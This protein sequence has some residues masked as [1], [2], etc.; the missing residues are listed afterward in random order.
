MP[1][2]PPRWRLLLLALAVLSL[3]I[4]SGIVWLF[5][6]GSFERVH[7]L[8]P[9]GPPAVTGWRFLWESSGGSR[10][11]IHVPLLNS[12]VFS[13]AVAL[14]VVVVS[15]MAAYAISRLSF[16]GRS[17]YL[18]LV[19][20][21]HAFPAVSLII[22]I[23]YILRLLGLFD[24]LAGVILVKASLEL[25]LGI[26][27]MKGFFD[28]LSWEMEMAALV[29]GMSRWAL[30]WKIALPLARP[31]VLALGTFSLLSAWGEF[32]LPFTL[33]VS[34]RSWTMAVYLQSFL[35]EVFTDYRMAA[36]AGLIYALPVVVL[37]F[38]GQRY[39]LNVY[40]G[41]IKG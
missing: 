37:F 6:S 16:P 29:D 40:S 17:L 39:L 18:G 8:L 28:S 22:A 12:L 21:L 31:G 38:L 15:S 2:L 3:P 13:V 7:G 25:P 27:L 35:G 10:P 32:I 30:F 33:I 36:A 24:T 1:L 41:G 14:V 9:V 23:F 11:P 19:L 34:T 4:L 26:W 5:L 20:V